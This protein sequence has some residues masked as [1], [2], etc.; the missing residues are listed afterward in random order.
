MY[1]QSKEGVSF[2]LSLISPKA[3]AMNI[4]GRLYQ[5]QY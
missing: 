5:A 1:G 2:P 3:E 4:L